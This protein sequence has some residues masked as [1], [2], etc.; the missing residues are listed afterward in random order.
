M[1]NRINIWV[2]IGLTSKVTMPVLS[3][4]DSAAV[5]IVVQPIAGYISFIQSNSANISLFT[6]DNGVFLIDDQ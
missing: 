3:Q 6:G 2:L 1:I 4:Q 5:Q